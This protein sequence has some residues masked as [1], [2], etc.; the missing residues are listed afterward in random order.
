MITISNLT[1]TTSGGKKILKNVSCTVQAGRIMMCVGKSGVGKTTL[2]RAIAGL[3]PLGY[4]GEIIIDGT[5]LMACTS[6][7]RPSLVGF[8]F[9]DFNLF[10]NLT[11]LDNC[12]NPMVVV[13]KQKRD[14][15]IHQAYKILA[16]L[17]IDQLKNVYP[18]SLSGGQKQRVAIARALCMGSRVLLL[19]EP[20]SALDPENTTKLVVMLK[21]LRQQGIAVILSSQDMN[22]VKKIDDIVCL[23]ED[24]CIVDSFDP[25]IADVLSEKTHLYEFMNA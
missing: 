18:K 13:K 7:E 6:Q 14:V 23:I 21:K 17:G 15:A 5:N 20:T 19:D 22:F 16:E 8:V 24:G 3:S 9:Q 1:V 4:E 11:V 25:Q 12:V 2:L 10:E